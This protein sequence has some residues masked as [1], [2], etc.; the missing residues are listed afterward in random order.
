MSVVAHRIPEQ[1]IPGKRLGR[2]YR[3]DTQN[4]AYIFRAGV[5]RAAGSVLHARRI[6]ILN[7]GNVGSCT[8][9]SS[10]GC[11]G[12]DPFFSTLPAN[13][14]AGLNQAFAY[15]MYSLEE[16][17][18]GYGPYP[19]NDNGGDGTAAAGVFKSQ[20][21]ISGY[22]HATSVTDMAAAVMTTPVIIGI[23]WYTSFD[24]PSSSG[25]I[26][27]AKSATVR[28]GH[29]V[30][31]R[32]ADNDSGIFYADNSWGTS[33]GVK[34]SFQL[35]FTVMDQLFGEGGDCTVFVPLSSP[36][37][38]PQPV[39]EAPAL[40]P[41]DLALAAV[42]KPWAAKVRLRHDL[43]EVSRALRE[44]EGAKGL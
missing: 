6:P 12:S 14:A 37:P 27:I 44:W 16:I 4:D 10:T 26:E 33:W 35:P 18:L 30:L 21:L 11:A 40:T 29:E 17:A 31:V 32:G 3:W 41:A 43:V 22:Q 13:V 8:M 19:P 36:A 38:T 15:K 34:G 42:T 5:M 7:Q 1:V 2:N 20:G 23:N 25:L 24:T 39:A 9:E 28:G